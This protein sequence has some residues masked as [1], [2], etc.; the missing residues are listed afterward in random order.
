[1]LHTQ[2][3][4]DGAQGN[5]A[6]AAIAI[7]VLFLSAACTKGH[8]QETEE[9][10]VARER[11]QLLNDSAQ[12]AKQRLGQFLLLANDSLEADLLV[13]NYYKKDG[14]WL[15]VT[16]DTTF[17]LR[18]ADT[19][20]SALADKAVSL[21]LEP[22]AFFVP[23]VKQDIEHLRVL[24]FDSACVVPVDAMARL[25]LSLSRAFM[26]CA[27]GLRYG[28]VDPHKAFNSLDP[29]GGGAF[30]QVY[31][32]ATER[33]TEDFLTESLHHVRDAMSYLDGLE[34]TDTIYQ[35]LKQRLATDTTK[36]GRK[37]AICNMERRRW[38]HKDAPAGDY[39]SPP[40]RYIFVNIPSQQLWAIAKDSV[41]SMKIC[42]GA[43]ATK[44]PLLYS[45]VRLIQLNPE[46]RIPYPIMAAE[47]SHHA[48]DSAYFARHDYFILK[49]STG[50][51]INP[52][53]ITADQLRQGGY[54]V[55]QHSGPRNALGR[56]IFR[57]PNKFDVY[58]HDT[59]NRRAFNA[60]R[61]TLSHGCVR[62][63][64]PFDLA[65]FL[66]PNADE[67]LL[68]QMRMTID[69]PPESDQGK[70]YLEKR[71]EE[72]MAKLLLQDAGSPQQEDAPIRFMSNQS[73]SP[74]VPVM[75]DYYTLYPNPETGVWETWRDRYEYDDQIMR[76]LERYC[77]PQL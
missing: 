50:D 19:L 26:R 46:W 75:I 8:L 17:L 29:R 53:S 52:K 33:P 30:R 48:G 55:T 28:F 49:N 6:I 45:N 1:M 23:Q 42:C 14:E 51:T 5:G 39:K 60:E 2:S 47:V 27:V 13:H 74:T 10:R 59:N 65:M 41:F 76:R 57:F 20:A 34:P 61:R 16:D 62:V 3:R 44:T 69:L 72:R 54:S 32:I 31:D 11:L 35:L 40:S 56:I 7:L 66:L 68:D 18:E 77:R 21:G 12:D 37:R 73:V 24:D 64:R 15:W 58:M 4:K 22:E 67:W 36:V 9:E 43:W 71:K 63:E 70:E 38:R 25:E